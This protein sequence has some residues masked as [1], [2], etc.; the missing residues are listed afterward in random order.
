MQNKNEN[1]QVHLFNLYGCLFL[2]IR[3]CLWKT[4][5][6]ATG[7][8]SLYCRQMH[9]TT[10][11][12]NWIEVLISKGHSLTFSEVITLPWFSRSEILRYRFLNV[13]CPVPNWKKWLISMPTFF[14]VGCCCCCCCFN[15]ALIVSYCYSWM[16]QIIYLYCLLEWGQLHFQW[17]SVLSTPVTLFSYLLLFLVAE[18]MLPLL[19]VL[20]FTW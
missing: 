20:S 16:L 3:S 10:L 2:R 17:V 11:C 7:R 1:K 6:V 19:L 8:S 15:A 13:M 4:I 5:L 14:W 9:K 18:S 12:C